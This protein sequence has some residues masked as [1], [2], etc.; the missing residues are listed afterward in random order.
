M[1]HS[2]L[3]VLT[4]ICLL[5]FLPDATAQTYRPGFIVR[6]EGDTLRGLVKYREGNARYASCIFKANE[7]A[8]SQEYGIDDIVA[9]GITNDAMFEV[10]TITN[11][12]QKQIKTFVEVLNHGKLS[13]YGYRNMFFLQKEN[14]DLHL[15]STKSNTSA[16]GGTVGQQMVSTSTTGH[17]ILLNTL[18]YDCPVPEELLTK[19]LRKVKG[20]DIQAIVVAYNN[21]ASPNNNITYKQDKPWVK[22]EKGI[23]IGS[24]A[25]SLNM[26][27]AY[28]SDQKA[29]FPLTSNLIVGGHFNLMSPRRSEKFSVI[30]D[31]YFSS[32]KYEGYHGNMR[33]NLKHRSDYSVEM[34]RLAA[35]TMARFNLGTY[36]KFNPYYGIGVA[37][38]YVIDSKATR[39][40]ET[41]ILVLGVRHVE[42]DI[43]ETDLN[44]SYHAGLTAALGTTYQ[45]NPKHKVA[46]QFRAERS[47]FLSRRAFENKDHSFNLKNSMTYYLTAAYILK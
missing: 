1:R 11:L 24:H 30:V 43:T 34:K 37:H 45:F 3:F 38:N 47:V 28:Y 27:T 18:T 16:V 21:C 8:A 14:E 39:R 5:A 13:L 4:A 25:A 10:K 36:Q 23:L 7:R 12:K 41:E 6:A 44:F 26:T 17:L 29:E 33:P 9:Y 22:I 42:T 31:A 35:V 19:V 2:Y 46:F 20:P 15:I 32:E 40:Q